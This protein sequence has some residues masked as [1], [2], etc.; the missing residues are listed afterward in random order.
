MAGFPTSW[1]SLRCYQHN[2]LRVYYPHSPTDK[3]ENKAFF[4]FSFYADNYPWYKTK[5]IAHMIL[6]Q[7]LSVGGC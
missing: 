1:K 3:A 5:E 7:P 6:L 4:F 2:S